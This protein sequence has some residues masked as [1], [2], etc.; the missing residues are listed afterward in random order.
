MRLTGTSDPVNSRGTPARIAIVGLGLMGGSLAAACRRKFKKAKII[1]ITRNR[2]ALTSALRRGWIH[3]GFTCLEEGLKNAEF[4]VLC[5]PVDKLPEY[6]LRIEGASSR[7]VLVTDVGSVKGG[8]V[9]WYAGRRWKHV[10]F[11]GAHPMVGSHERGI[12]AASKLL[13]RDA[14]VF[15]TPASETSRK[16]SDAAARFWKKICSRIVTVSPERHDEIVARISHLPHAVAVA[17]MN[18]TSPDFFPFSASGFRDTTRI[19]GSHPS[20]WL[21]IFLAN[22]KSLESSLRSFERSLRQFRSALRHGRQKNLLRLLEKAFLGR[23][24]I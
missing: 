7:Q 2:A 8:I 23:Q 24:Q 14:L 13:Y 5:T 10:R 12:Q 20:V 15:M 17:L 21:P 4:V 1:G 6:L 9:R 19:A 22:R 3:E 16:H 11:V 18:A